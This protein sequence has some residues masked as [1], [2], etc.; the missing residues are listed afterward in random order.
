MAYDEIYLGEPSCIPPVTIMNGLQIED[1]QNINTCSWPRSLWSVAREPGRE[2][3]AGIPVSAT[4]VR[5]FGGAGLFDVALRSPRPF[6][7]G[8]VV[9][10]T[11]AVVTLVPHSQKFARS[12][13]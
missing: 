6:L 10:R 8:R 12:K 13:K 11:E 4:E 3:I 5:S 1:E 2:M 9:K 7:A